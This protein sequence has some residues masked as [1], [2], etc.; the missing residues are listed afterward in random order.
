MA[1]SCG[2]QN[3]AGAPDQALRVGTRMAFVILTS[4]VPCPAAASTAVDDL[5][6]YTITERAH[7]KAQP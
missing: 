2:A 3:A 1:L 4:M 6:I 5:F 7:T